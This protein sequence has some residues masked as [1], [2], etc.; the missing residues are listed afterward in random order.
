MPVENKY[1]DSN[2][3]LGKKALMGASGNEIVAYVATFEVAAAD[4]DGSIY[5]VIKDI[6]S[7]LIPLQISILCDAITGGTDWDLGVYKTNLGAVVVKDNLMNGQTLATALTRITGHQIGLKDVN[8][9]AVRSTLATLSGQTNPDDS[10]DLALTA[11]TVGTAAGT[12]SI[13]AEFLVAV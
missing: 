1:V 8:V 10:Y 3:V 12:V 9:D 5:R 6:P 2:I 13:L 7:N 4:D 11:N